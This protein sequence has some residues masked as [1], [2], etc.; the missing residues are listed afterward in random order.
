[1][2]AA[3]PVAVGGPV[4][5]FEPARISSGP[6][7]SRRAWLA[8]GGSAAVVVLAVAAFLVLR[9]DPPS[10]AGA[11]RDY[12]D[13]LRSGDTAAALAL[14][15]DQGGV[16]TPDAA[17][18]LVPAALAGA[19]NRPT[20]A[21]VTESQAATSGGEYTAVAVTYRIGG[22]SVSQVLAVRATG[23]EQTPY[24]LEQP[25]LYLTVEAPYGMAATVNGITVDP[26]TLARG[27]PVFPGAYEATTAGN[28]LFAGGTQA[29][30][31][32]SGNRSVTADIRFGSPAVAP[33][34]PQAVQA[35]VQ[36]Y[37]DAACVNPTGSYR[38]RCPLQAPYMSYSQTTSW[39]IT[40][41]PQ[42]Q[43]SQADSGRNQVQFATGTPGSATYTISYTDYTGVQQSSTGS[44]SVSVRGYAGIGNDGAI[45]ITLGY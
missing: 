20:D 36:Q 6:Q 39:K 15:D 10:P 17:P 28:A 44:S 18:L 8:I 21:A 19:G 42:V 37:L 31:Y 38:Y 32:Q 3:R 34:A 25:F 12:F 13:H 45:Q 23:D 30:T 4:H 22:Q 2:A 26:G 16:I 35:A 9:P 29:A 24:R 40:T 1:M 7:L 14:V 11:V 41:Y 43:L 33:G 5:R 27:T